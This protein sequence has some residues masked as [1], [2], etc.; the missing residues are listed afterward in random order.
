MSSIAK[1]HFNVSKCLVF[2]AFYHLKEFFE[3]IIHAGM[4]HILI[5][6]NLNPPLQLLLGYLLNTFSSKFHSLSF[7]LFYFLTY[8]PLDL[9]GAACECIDW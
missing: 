3:N 7:I 2:I 4:H 5:T 1:I 8:K 9:T 6:L